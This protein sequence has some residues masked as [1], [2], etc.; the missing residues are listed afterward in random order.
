MNTPEWLD[1]STLGWV[2][3]YLNEELRVTKKYI[4]KNPDISTMGLH[5]LK[6]MADI[7]QRLAKSISNRRTRVVNGRFS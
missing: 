2:C 4:N 6:G 7:L 3:D 1:S 5:R